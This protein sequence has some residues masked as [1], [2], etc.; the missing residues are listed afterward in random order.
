MDEKLVNSALEKAMELFTATVDFTKEQ[1]PLVV[2]EYLTYS[3]YSSSITFIYSFITVV[4]S[5]IG[6]IWAY[7]RIQSKNTDV[8]VTASI[9]LVA[10]IISGSIG[11]SNTMENADKLL[12]IKFAPRIFLLEKASELTR[13]KPNGQ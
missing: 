1:V 12:K 2:Q 11:V 6:V 7:P 8:F 13:G 4:A 3:L 10:S 5:I 9:A